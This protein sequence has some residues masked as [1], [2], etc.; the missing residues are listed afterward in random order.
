M[1][2]L[3]FPRRARNLVALKLLATRFRLKSE[4]RRVLALAKALL[5]VLTFCFRDL[6]L[7]KSGAL[8]LAKA[9]LNYAHIKYGRNLKSLKEKAELNEE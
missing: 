2:F 8:A 9:R 3:D 1:F 5:E 6:A 7:A 4:S